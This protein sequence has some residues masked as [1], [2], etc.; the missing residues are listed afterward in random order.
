MRRCAPPGPGAPPPQKGFEFD[1]AFTSLLKRAI[2]TLWI[3]LDNMDLMWIPVTRSWRLNERHYGDLQVRPPA[4]P[5]ARPPP[6][7]RAPVALRPCPA[8]G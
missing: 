8:V 1:C 4:R 2:R 7:V 5:P 6:C 3:T